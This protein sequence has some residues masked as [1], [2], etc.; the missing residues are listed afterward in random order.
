M[1][2]SLRTAVVAAAAVAAA[3]VA[4]VAVAPV[5]VGGAT[6]PAVAAAAAPTAADGAPAWAVR[7]YAPRRGNY[8]G[9]TPLLRPCAPC[10]RTVRGRCAWRTT[11]ARSATGAYRCVKPMGFGGK[12]TDPCWTCAGG[13]TCGAKG[14]CERPPIP[15]CKPCGGRVRGRCAPGTTCTKNNKGTHTCVKSVA[16]GAK[17]RSDCV[18]CRT[19]LTCGATGFCAPPVIDLCKPCGGYIVGKCAAE[20]E[21]AKNNKGVRSCVK[22]MGAGGK[23][24]DPCWTCKDGLKC[25]AKG[26]CELP[27]IR[28]C[29]PCGGLI[30]GTCE[31]GTEC[32]K[33]NKGVRSCVKPM[34][35]G[36][37]CTDPCWTCK[38]GLKCGAKGTC[39]LPVIRQCKPCGGLILGTCEAGTEC[40]KNNKGIRSCVKPMGAGGK[41]TDPCWTCTD[42]LT[43]GAKGT[44]EP[45]L[46]RQCKPC[47]G[48]ILGTCEAGTECAKNNKGTR[49]CVKSVTTG[50]K[51]RSDCV[52]CRA[53]LTCG[54]TGFCAPPVIDLCKPCGG[55]IVGKCA[56]ESE[57]A[58]NNKGVRSCVKRM[59]AGGKC[60][61]P[62]WTCKDGLTCGAKG[63]CELPVIRQCKPCG[64]LILGTCEAGTEC[65]KNNKGVRSCVKPMGAGGKCTDPCWTCKDGLTCGA[66]GTCEPPL[67]RQCKPCGGLILGTC[68]AG[69]ECAKNNKGVRSCVKPMGAGGKCTDPCWTCKDGLTCGQA[70]TCRRPGGYLPEY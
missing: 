57:C 58:K 54:T 13:L 63:T 27:V 20:S 31:A 47:G 10:G 7:R 4:T 22:R 37:K 64:G 17:C 69:T 56:A 21:C 18:V 36:G 68:E 15:Q 40:A 42:G 48:L 43:C 46:I 24:T 9:W 14:T 66:K 49:T 5:P 50:A 1:A 32:A 3:V 19:G 23:C 65:A 55:Y 28:Q 44:C 45:P 6:A 60:T 59:G 62:C 41:C 34:G 30:L 16:T 11:C 70:G 33:N 26:T 67:I 51:C 2:F 61:D 25:G 35:A 53:G 52:A 29:K 39:E 8:Y 38:D 12:C